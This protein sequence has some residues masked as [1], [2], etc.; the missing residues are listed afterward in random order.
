M[1]YKLLIINLFICCQFFNAQENEDFKYELLGNLILETGELYSYKVIF[2]AYDNNF[3]KGY[4]YTDLGGENETKSYVRGYYDSKTKKIRFKENDVLYTKSSF[5]PEDFCF[6]N[7]SGKFK[8]CTKK[9]RLTG[10][11]YGI[12]DD[13][14]TCATGSLNLVSVKFAEKKIAKVYKKIK[15]IDNIKKLDSAAKEK[16]NPEVVLKKFSETKIK[17]G[18]QVTVF[19]YNPKMKLDIWDYGKEDGDVI[20]LYQNGKVILKDYSVTKKKKSITLTLTDKINKI[21][22]KNNNAGKLKSNTTKLKIYDYRR[23]YEIVA[24]IEEGKST[25]LNIVKLEVKKK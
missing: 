19:V 7:F 24:D 17:S 14:D 22:V 2:N 25:T 21:E 20:T 5:L 12:Y 8:S 13:K 15:R 18:E 23:Q 4:S 16:F 6:V 9:Q 1:R 10:S 11:F 3:I